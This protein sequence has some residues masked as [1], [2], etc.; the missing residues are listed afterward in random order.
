MCTENAR[1]DN[2][3]AQYALLR[4]KVNVQNT[5]PPLE[6]TNKGMRGSAG[7]RHS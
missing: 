3:R 4:N 6:F 5:Q 1:T 2:A 7:G